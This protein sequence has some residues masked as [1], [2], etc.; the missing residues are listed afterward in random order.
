MGGPF[1]SGRAL[2]ALL[3]LGCLAAPGAASALDLGAYGRVWP[4]AERSFLEWMEQR[5]EALLPRWKQ[6]MGDA[7]RR[8]RDR[9]ERPPPTRLPAAPA[10][11]RWLHDPTYVAPRTVVDHRGRALVL[12]GERINPLDQV[13]LSQTLVFFAGDE[14]RQRSWVRSRADSGGETWILTSGP[15][16]RLLKEW[17]RRLYFDQGGELLRRLGI[18]ALPATVRQQGSRLVLEEWPL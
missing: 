9:V 12:A 18:E 16:M 14:P 1:V 13:S 7:R 8:Y 6:L 2:V 4:L 10:Y 11:R 15:Y 17:R 3:S 5:A